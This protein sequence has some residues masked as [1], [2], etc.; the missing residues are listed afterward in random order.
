MNGEAER[1]THLD[2]SGGVRMVDVGGKEITRRVAVAAC[3][4][5]MKPDTLKAIVEDRIKKGSVLTVAKIAA[6]GAAK[7]TG[8]LIPL[9][10]GLSPDHVDVRFEHD[11]SEGVLDI[12]ASVT[13]HAKTGAEMEA[14]QAA[15][16]A[17][18]TV[19]DMCKAVDRGIVISDLRL[20][21]KEGGKSGRWRRK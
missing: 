17:S 2:S 6:I 5:H 3:R 9:C 19:Y 20:I 18:L 13:V 8:E 14:L 1:F 16:Q 15:A 12:T 11:V 10:H 4:M 7:R 21:E